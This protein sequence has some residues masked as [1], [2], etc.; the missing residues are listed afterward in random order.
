MLL[1]L[2]L[3][4]NQKYS[5]Q[6]YYM[7]LQTQCLKFQLV[8]SQSKLPLTYGSRQKYFDSK[9]YTKSTI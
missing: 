8:S 3:P 7:A 4:K 6:V 5:A 9:I 2:T 1:M